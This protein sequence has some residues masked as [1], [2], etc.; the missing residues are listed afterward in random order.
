[1][2]EIALTSLA[3]AKVNISE[4]DK[5]ELLRLYKTIG[6]IFTESDVFRCYKDYEVWRNGCIT[7]WG[8]ANTVAY[9]KHNRVCVL[10]NMK[11]MGLK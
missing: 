2:Q 5:E 9:I 10:G 6:P 4:K 8:Y 3:K 1:M 7:C 11:C